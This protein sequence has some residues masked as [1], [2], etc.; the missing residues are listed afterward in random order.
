MAE[1]CGCQTNNSIC[2]QYG[3]NIFF[4]I[5]IVSCRTRNVIT[6]LIYSSGYLNTS[7]LHQTSGLARSF[8][9]QARTDFQIRLKR[10]VQRPTHRAARV[11][12]Y[13]RV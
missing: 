10:S 3:I 11:T 2:I 4:L 12:M 13:T 8:V 1:V 9:S 6:L 7:L 5:N